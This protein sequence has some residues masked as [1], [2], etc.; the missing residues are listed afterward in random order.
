MGRSG[1]DGSLYFFVI[2]DRRPVVGTAFYPLGTA[3]RSG[4]WTK[5]PGQEGQYVVWTV[6][7]AAFELAVIQLFV[8]F[9]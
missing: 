1:I 6:F 5:A 2:P 7:D 8:P 9:A 4:R 3:W